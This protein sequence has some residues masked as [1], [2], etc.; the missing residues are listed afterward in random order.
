MTIELTTALLADEARTFAEIESRYDE[1]RLFG[2]TDGKA[3]GTYLEQKFSHYV[4][5]KYDYRIGNS[6]SGIDFPDLGVDIKVTSIKQPQSSSPFRSARQKVYGLGYHLLV[7]VYEKTDDERTRTSRL[8][9]LHTIFVTQERTAD[10]QMTR[11]LL[12]LLDNQGN[13]DDIIAFF[14]EKN[15]PLD[16][17]GAA[18]LA[19]EVLEKRPVQGYLT[20][21]NALQW[22][23]QYRRAI[24]EAGQ[25]EGL[26]RIR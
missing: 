17:I 22:R 11:G 23:L 21:S 7:F 26:V 12:N 18:A 3:V 13:E 25:V 15:L 4:A 10:F 2:V 5:Q 8:D 24:D 1:A 9:I 19:R 14:F 20:I 6:A 16:E